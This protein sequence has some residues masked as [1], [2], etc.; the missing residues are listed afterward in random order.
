MFNFATRNLEKYKYNNCKFLWKRKFSIRRTFEKIHGDVS[1]SD[2]E[3]VGFNWLMWLILIDVIDM[4]TSFVIKW[5]TTIYTNKYASYSCIPR[6]CDKKIG[7]DFSVLR[8][9]VGSKHFIGL[10]EIK[11]PFWQS[12]LMLWLDFNRREIC[13]VADVR[14][15]ANQLLWNIVYIQLI[16]NLYFS[17]TRS[18]LNML[19]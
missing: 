16:S 8:S 2:F 6:L 17:G 10:E 5:F 15:I 9:S 7:M 14:D 11:S 13:N 19:V 4:Q 12:A 18:M 3:D 1:Y